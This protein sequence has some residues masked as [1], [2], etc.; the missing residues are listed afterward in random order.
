MIEGSH[1]N[2]Q[3][4]QISTVQV[5]ESGQSCPLFIQIQLVECIRDYVA[6]IWRNLPYRKRRFLD[7]F[8]FIV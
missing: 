5:L 8:E 6:E 7:N 2:L 3:Y 1:E 4:L